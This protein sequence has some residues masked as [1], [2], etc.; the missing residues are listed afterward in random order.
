MKE[1]IAPNCNIV[2]IETEGIMGNSQ[3]L[4]SGGSGNGIP[5][6]TSESRSLLWED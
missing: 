4:Y 3:N 2:E 1:Y 6:E 5:N